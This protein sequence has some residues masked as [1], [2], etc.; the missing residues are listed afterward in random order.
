MRSMRPLSVAGASLASC[1]HSR[2]LPTVRQRRFIPFRFFASS[3]LPDAFDAIDERDDHLRPPSERGLSQA[4]F[5]AL[6][7]SEREEIRERE[8][9]L[10]AAED[11]IAA[12]RPRSHQRSNDDDEDEDDADERTSTA[13]RSSSSPSSS[14][15]SLLF[16]DDDV[17]DTPTESD[18]ESAVPSW[19]HMQT[20]NPE[21]I[22][23]LPGSDPDVPTSV[24]YPFI[25]VLTSPRDV[26]DASVMHRALQYARLRSTKQF[27]ALER[28]RR[29]LQYQREY[30]DLSAFLTSLLPRLPSAREDLASVKPAVKNLP[31]NVSREHL[32]ET[33]PHTVPTDTAWMGELLQ[34]MEAELR[35]NGV[36]STAE[37]ERLLTH[38]VRLI[39]WV[40]RRMMSD[41]EKGYYR[42][43]GHVSPK[44][45][46]VPFELKV[47]PPVTRQVSSTL[48]VGR[49]HS[50]KQGQTQ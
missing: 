24:R 38:T 34:L 45:I 42:V 9:D 3:R 2:P 25:P 32:A 41:K 5:D 6:P 46:R 44:E 11:A 49:V 4:E 17:S 15:P 48:R 39:A 13:L 23:P 33:H 8:R 35:M 28:R 7:E 20:A 27:L 12:R 43:M 21:F 47:P 1:L 30:R 22:A 19:M 16:P 26:A 37:K 40:Y 10:M 14:Q 31:T 36:L 18:Y 29:L 50:G